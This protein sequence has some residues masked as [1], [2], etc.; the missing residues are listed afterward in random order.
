[1]WSRVGTGSAGATLAAIGFALGAAAIV[2]VP[3]AWLDETVAPLPPSVAVGLG[4]PPWVVIATALTLVGLGLAWLGPVA[5]DGRHW[6][7]RTTGLLLGALGVL[8]WLTGAPAGWRWGLSMTGPAR[9]LMQLIGG[10]PS[11]VNW[12]TML[13]IGVPLGTWVSARGQGPVRWRQRPPADL[14]RR[15]IGGVLMGAGGT[16]A[17]GCNIGNALTGLSTL[18]LNSVIATVA[19]V[20]G[21]AVAMIAGRGVTAFRALLSAPQ[22]RD[23]RS[24]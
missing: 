15:G 20:A 14:A 1:M 23:P 9:S 19:I 21:G 11:A 10:N 16:L 5:P 18:A 8:A 3:T 4:V 22:A 17:A 24:P 6:R 13:L 12:G 7:W 2:R